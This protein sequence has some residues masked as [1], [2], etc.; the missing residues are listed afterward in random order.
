[1]CPLDV[2]PLLNK[3]KNR[4]LLVSAC[5]V[6]SANLHLLLGALSKSF[7]C[8]CVTEELERLWLR[9]LIEMRVYRQGLQDTMILSFSVSFLLIT[10]SCIF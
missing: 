8:F 7:C 4:H 1:M 2:F 10:K 9:A 3:L 6:T 5:K